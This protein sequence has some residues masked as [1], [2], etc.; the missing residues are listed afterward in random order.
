MTLNTKYM[1]IELRSPIIAGSSPLTNSKENL[2]KASDFGIGAIVLKSIFEQQLLRDI[3]SNAN[4]KN[5]Q[6]NYQES[7]V[8]SK[9]FSENNIIENFLN[10][11]YYANSEL[12]IP[13]IASINCISNNVW[14]QFA[15][16]FEEAGADAI[17]LN[18]SLSNYDKSHDG[19]FIINNIVEIVNSVRRNCTIPVSVKLPPFI[20]NP[21]YDFNLIDETGVE[22]IVLFNK[23]FSPQIDIDTLKLNAENSNSFFDIENALRW[24]ALLSNK[25]KCDIIGSGGVRDFSDAI[26]YILCGAKAVQVTSSF[27]N[28]GFEYIKVLNDGIENWMNEKGF[29]SINDFRGLISNNH[30]NEVL[31]KQ[32]QYL[33]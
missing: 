10:L 33:R 6:A 30:E 16:K 13:V 21:F 20:T 2:K 22:S 12:K 32:V 24:T 4:Q 26:K 31:F 23:L 17:E 14:P 9:D 19:S 15:L 25:L 7:D 8:D 5:F 3:K 27:L 11:I 28:N 29:N 1:G 18:I